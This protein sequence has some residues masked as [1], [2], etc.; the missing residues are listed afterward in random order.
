[1]ARGDTLDLQVLCR[2]ACKFKD[3]GREVFEDGGKVDGCFGADACLLARNCAKVALYATA[4][5]L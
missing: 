1:M 4:W 5:E 3:F 2:I